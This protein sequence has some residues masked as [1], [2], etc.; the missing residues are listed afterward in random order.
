MVTMPKGV[1]TG[2]AG[3]A[4]A[5]IVSSRIRA[6]APRAIA[7]ASIVTRP[8]TAGRASTATAAGPLAAV[9]GTLA[10]EA[11]TV[12]IQGGNNDFP[13][14][15]VRFTP[16]ASARSRAGGAETDATS[17]RNKGHDSLLA[18]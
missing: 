14:T 9:T 12:S 17:E 16:S 15:I 2:I 5:N 10:T 18:G 6:V 8:V 7:T 11:V 13:F 1:R 4:N 3:L